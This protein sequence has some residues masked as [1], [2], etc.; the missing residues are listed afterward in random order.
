[1]SRRWVKPS[2][3]YS[4]IAA[5]LVAMA[6]RNGV[7]PRATMPAATARVSREARPWPRHAGSVQTA[8]ISVQPGARIR[9]PAIATS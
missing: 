7:S 5:V 4:L 2:S 3:V 6:C 9:S 8:L 1:M